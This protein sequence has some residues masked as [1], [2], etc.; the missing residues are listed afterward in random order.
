MSAFKDYLKMFSDKKWLEELKDWI[1]NDILENDTHTFVVPPNKNLRISEGRWKLL[2]GH[3]VNLIHAAV[4][5]DASEKEL[6]NMYRYLFVCMNCQKYRLDPKAAKE[7][8]NIEEY[9]NKYWRKQA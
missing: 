7:A 4:D 1:G 8:L 6:R 2:V 5:G 9:E 3:A